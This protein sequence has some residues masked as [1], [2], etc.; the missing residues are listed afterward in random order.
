M[1]LEQPRTS[2]AI[3][4]IAAAVALLFG[5]RDAALA[6]GATQP[7]ASVNK[8]LGAI[9]L[10]EPARPQTRA[11]AALACAMCARPASSARTARSTVRIPMS[12]VRASRLERLL[13]FRSGVVSA[14]FWGLFDRGRGIYVKYSI[15][16]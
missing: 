7:L 15:H 16:F 2:R 14:N 1:R 10:R 6:L 8:Q 9:A 3:F 13:D 11:T 12:L 5:Q 4:T